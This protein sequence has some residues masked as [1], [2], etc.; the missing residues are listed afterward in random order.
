MQGNMLAAQSVYE[1]TPSHIVLL[2]ASLMSRAW[3]LWELAV[4]K[5]AGQY[6]VP[7]ESKLPKFVQGLRSTGN[8]FQ[9][10]RASKEDDCKV[11]RDKI[12]STFKNA[13]A[14]NVEMKAIFLACGGSIVVSEFLH[15]FYF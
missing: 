3:C 4:R 8:F 6:T 12:N 14:F 15:Q 1:S 13:T 11:I 9:E 7:I 10:M 2:T 5:S